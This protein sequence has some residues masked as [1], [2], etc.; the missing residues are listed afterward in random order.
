MMKGV[1]FAVL[2]TCILLL[3]ATEIFAL[4]T[5]G[6][7]ASGDATI[8]Q[9]DATT[10]ILTQT[11]DKTVIDWQ[12][13][14]TSS[15]ETHVYTQPGSTS[16]ALNRIVS[17]S[18]PVIAGTLVANGNVW[19]TSTNG[20]T[21]GNNGLHVNSSGLLL[22]SYSP[23]GDC[24][25]D[26]FTLTRGDSNGSIRLQGPITIET[27]K[28]L[29]IVAPQIILESGVTVTVGGGTLILAAGNKISVDLNGDPKV[30]IDEP[31]TDPKIEINGSITNNGGE[32]I[33]AAN[34]IMS[35]GGT[36]NT[37]AGGSVDM[38]STQPLNQST[39]VFS[40]ID[41]PSC[42]LTGFEVTG[43]D[44]FI[45]TMPLWI[46]TT[47]AEGSTVSLNAGDCTTLGTWKQVSG[48]AVTLSSTTVSSPTFVV[49][50]VTTAGAIL[51]FEY[52][53]QSESGTP[54]TY[55][56]ILNATDNGITYFPSDV[57][58]FKSSTGE[59][60]GI[61]PN[62]G[63]LTHLNPIDPADLTNTA[64]QPDNPIYGVVDMEI[65]VFNPG[66]T[67]TVTVYLPTPAPAGYK[68][69][70]YNA[71]SGWYDFSEHAVFNNDRTQVTL[72]LVDGGIGDDDG[73]ANG[74]IKDPSGLGEGEAPSVASGEGGGGGNC[75][76]AT[77][78]YGSALDAHV[79]ILR[80]FRDRFLLTNAA[81]RAFVA[82]YYKH[83]P[84]LASYISRHDNLRAVVR[85]C[86]LPLIGVSWV[87]LNLGS[88]AAL[89]ILLLPLIFVLGLVVYR[90][91]RFHAL[92]EH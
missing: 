79:S 11:T 2:I 35:A 50:A 49:P 84:A 51:T 61:R 13:Y 33:I 17:S 5:G 89:S 54:V 25:A 34:N 3:N 22:S 44:V 37:G 58:T 71:Q 62:S 31:G 80:A 63:A 28:T 52:D 12:T 72:T 46:L 7:V 36:I 1:R 42:T 38:Y 10:T 59:N 16:I 21:V 27:G 18:P 91:Q 68:W 29:V 48:P 15:G 24:T 56:V 20:M 60:M 66:D 39:V 57:T 83:S 55:S 64:N 32:I 6:S 41:A 14:N 23:S 69:F 88:F 78:A 90:R 70:K 81:G 43:M 53:T 86:L 65:K 26:K 47:A 77:A 19:I 40:Y 74:V 85:V 76:I 87:A 9:P 75:F 8:S 73:I 4:P 67:A 30:T 92:R 82:F 45:G